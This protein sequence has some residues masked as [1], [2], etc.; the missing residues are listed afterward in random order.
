MKSCSICQQMKN[1]V[2]F[3]PD[4]RASDCLQS[5][6]KKCYSDKRKAD[7]LVKKQ[8]IDQRNK[9]WAKNNKNIANSIK[10]KWYLNNKEK[11]R[12]SSNKWMDNN[13]GLVNATASKRRSA[14]LK[15]TPKWLTEEQFKEIKSWYILAKELQW[16]SEAP[17]EVDHIVPLQGELVSGLHV[18][19][20]LQI[21][22]KSLN[23]SKGNKLGGLHR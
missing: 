13:R 1:S 5:C 20:N 23:A 7:Y 17:L 3:S 14:K 6:C 11:A 12:I 10:L 22:P 18:P 15:R 9:K 16:L 4:S 19:W 8:E 21:L 2:D